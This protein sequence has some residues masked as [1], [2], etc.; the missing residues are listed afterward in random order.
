[1]SISPFPA[2]KRELVAH[3]G[4]D[5]N[6]GVQL[7]GRRFF[8]DQTVTELLVE[9]LLVAASDKRIG[10]V[11]FSHPLPALELLVDWPAKQE[12]ADN[13][14]PLEYAPKARL[15]LKLFAFLGASKLDT[16]HLTHRNHYKDLLNELRRKIQT[17]GTTS[18]DDVLRTLEN[19][20]LGY[21]GV[22][23]QRTWCAQ[24]FLPIGRTFISAE[25]LWNETEA[26]QH[27]IDDW[28]NLLGSFTKYFSLN[29]HRFLARGGELLY[30]QLCNMLRQPISRIQEWSKEISLGVDDKETDPEQLHA[31]L[32]KVFKEVL[33]TCP[34]AVERLAEFIDEGVET[35]T[36]HHTDSDKDGQRRF[37]ACGWCPEESWPE[38]YLF[39]LEFLRLCTAQIDPMERLELLELLCAMQVI[40]SLC[41]Q[42]VRYAGENY[43]QKLAGPLGYVFAI[44]DPDGSHQALK[45]ISRRSVSACERMI[46]AA[47]RNPQIK[48]IIRQ[49]QG[50]DKDSYETSIYKEA[51]SR[52]GYKYFLALGK[53]M[54]MIIPRR[55]RGA[56][57]VINERL[58]RL[59]VLT[60]MRPGQRITYTT[61]KRMALVHYGMAFDDA[62]ISAASVWSGGPSILTLGGNADQ[63]LVEMLDS[64]GV[65]IRLSDSSAMVA[66]PSEGVE[67]ELT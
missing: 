7:F 62:N 66:S 46:Y 60:V 3:R 26:I 56:R 48:G 9:M 14:A 39:A 42:S 27:N 59:L 4:E 35:E 13:A 54:G 53:R 24:S 51:D 41:A 20:F 5:R 34:Q 21:Q 2:I 44:S 64:A 29:R 25:T 6:P 40:R 19:L 52:Y 47:M 57:F 33:N 45:Q 16:R 11:S 65:L 43:Q 1:M 55:G 31:S 49:K 8:A 37:T 67:E 15:N 18:T 23:G 63:W 38:G 10:K 61:F 50:N 28:D 36:A 30:L 58:L 32:M 22:G 12:A 17:P